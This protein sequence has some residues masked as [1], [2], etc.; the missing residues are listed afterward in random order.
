MKQNELKKIISIEEKLDWHITDENGDF[1]IDKYSPAGQD[2]LIQLSADSIEEFVNE[3][4]GRYN[5]FDCS[6]EAYLWLDESGH[7]KNGA[8]YDMKDV[9]E[10]MEA[11]KEM[12]G[13]L[14]ETFRNS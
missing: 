7:G 12:I 10:D 5:N 8:P 4:K 1:E 14:V 3:L 2:F 13:E 6:E 11:C 9:Y